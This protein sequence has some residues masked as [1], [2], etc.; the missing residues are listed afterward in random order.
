MGFYMK[1]V[2]LDDEELED[3]LKRFDEGTRNDFEF[4]LAAR[5][6]NLVDGEGNELSEEVKKAAE[7]DLEQSL[8]IEQDGRNV[9]IINMLGLV[10][11]DG[12]F[13][14]YKGINPIG[15]IEI[16]DVN[17]DTAYIM[18]GKLFDPVK[19]AKDKELR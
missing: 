13:F 9:T 1:P 4:Y 5:E 18:N 19:D 12:D 3:H 8:G 7:E 17:G 10:V 2:P 6:D 16:R 14:I 11:F 15:N